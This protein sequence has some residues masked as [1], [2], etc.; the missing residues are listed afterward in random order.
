MRD[1]KVLSDAD[2]AFASPNMASEEASPDN[3]E[4]LNGFRAKCKAAAGKAGSVAVK[5][6]SAKARQAAEKAA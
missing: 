3:E 5:K 1:A 6:A 2:C 4:E